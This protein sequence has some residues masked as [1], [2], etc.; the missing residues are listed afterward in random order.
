MQIASGCAA[1]Q[2]TDVA[3]RWFSINPTGDFN[4]LPVLSLIKGRR[5]RR[6]IDGGIGELWGFDPD[7]R[8]LWKNFYCVASNYSKAGEHALRHGSLGKVLRA[9]AAIPG[10]L[11]PVVH[12]GDLLCDGGTFNNFPVDIMQGARG[13]GT[14]IGVDLSTHKAR[15]F[16]S[17]HVPGTWTLLRDRLR[18]Y[19]KRRYRFPSLLAYL[20]NV[21]ILYSIS[22]QEGKRKLTDFYFNPPLDRVGML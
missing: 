16:E 7:V 14:V 20:M 1:S 13:V 15:R 5:L 6:A 8:D 2:L 11:P 22:R 3:R 19:A 18:P 10:A 9:S 21:Q 4:L 17:E 12:D